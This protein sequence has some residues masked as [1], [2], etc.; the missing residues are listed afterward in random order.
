MKLL[1]TNKNPHLPYFVSLLQVLKSCTTQLNLEFC[2]DCLIIQGMDKSHVCLFDIR[3]DATWFDQYE[4]DSD[5]IGNIGVVTTIFTTI[6]TSYGTNDMI[7]S[8]E[9]N[10]E[11][12]DIELSKSSDNKKPIQGAY[13]CHYKI[14]IIDIQYDKLGI[15][16]ME[17]EAECTIS[18][19]VLND[20]LT[21]MSLFGERIR[22][23]C[24]EETFVLTSEGENG[25][26]SVNV[27]TEQLEEYCIS[28][29]ETI[30][31]DYSLT[32][33]HKM[34]VTTKLSGNIV[35]YFTKDMPLKIQYDLG[36]DSQ[37]LFYLAPKISNE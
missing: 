7:L 18:A 35:L 22:F 6:L 13:D 25:E 36:K 17:Y 29:G 34:I 14:P 12:L 24:Q 1:L 3:L 26:M 37:V 15:P 16:E 10:A 11:T 4:K 31:V 32:Y 5:D 28:E 9:G 2:S 19:Y 33:L 27:P 20:I 8:Y 30:E 21:K 23:T